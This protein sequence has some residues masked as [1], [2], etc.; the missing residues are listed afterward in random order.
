MPSERQWF[1]S[2]GRDVKSLPREYRIVDP[3][4]R[5]RIRNLVLAIVLVTL[6]II[7]NWGGP[8]R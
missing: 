7:G 6:F 8:V 3:V 4:R 1:E 5:A 2:L